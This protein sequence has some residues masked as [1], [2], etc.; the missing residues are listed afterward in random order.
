MSKKSSKKRTSSSRSGGVEIHANTVNIQGDVAGRDKAGSGG[1]SPPPPPPSGS[2]S[3]P[4][5]T[6]AAFQYDVFISY[7]SQD[8]DWVRGELLHALEQRGLRVLIDFRDF[9]PG[10][11]SIKEIERAILISRKTLLILTPDYLASQWTEFENLLLQ[12]L[13]PSNQN[14]RLI[15]LLKA[16]C[17]LPLRLRML[18]YVNFVDP[19]DWDSAWRQLFTALGA[20][21]L[22]DAPTPE[23]PEA[24]FLKHPYG[25]PP[26]FTGRAAEKALLTAWLNGNTGH[27]LWV[28]RAL[29]GF[30]KSA[31]AWHWLTHDVKDKQWPRV[32]WWSFYEGDASF[33]N[34]LRETLAYLKIDPPPGP[35]GQVDALL[36]ALRQPGTLL[37]LDGFERQLRVFSGMNAAY[38]GDLPLPSEG[39][40]GPVAKRSGGA[41]VSATA[42]ASAPSPKA[43][44]ATSPRCPTCAAKC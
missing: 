4:P 29:G 30:G 22:Q 24:W 1:S 28:M 36:A 14:L 43:S 2:P 3:T 15:P 31:L 21:P 18:T 16:K 41:G 8:K 39:D 7:S 37:I 9:R 42:T 10:A 27:S 17:D 33:E 35:R 12:T 6:D 44:C 23:T 38:Q 34:F 25:M 40:P 32:V 11:P 20:P 26:N 5:P 19:D 13:E